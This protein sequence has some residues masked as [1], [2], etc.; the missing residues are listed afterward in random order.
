MND[1]SDGGGGIAFISFDSVNDCHQC[2]ISANTSPRGGGAHLDLDANPQFND[3][4]FI[5][6]EASDGG[7]IYVYKGDPTFNDCGIVFN[8]AT[9]NGGGI[10]STQ[11]G[12]LT[13][14]FG[15]ILPSSMA[16]ELSSMVV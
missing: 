8:T 14:K 6:N 13:A 10:C 5:T 7:G 9:E 12:T 4:T 2:S 1:A 11:E 3:C 16:A 15:T